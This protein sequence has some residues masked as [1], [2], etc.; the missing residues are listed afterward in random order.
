MAGLLGLL[1]L[2]AGAITAQDAGVAVSGRNTANVNT[3]GYSVESVNLSAQVGGPLLSGVIA[4]DTT[5]STDDFLSSQEWQ[6]AG[7]LGLSST[8][9]TITS[10]LTQVLT[11]QGQSL[12]QSY[13]SLFGSFNALA[14]SP[15]DTSLRQ[16]VVS[17]AQQMA[18]SYQQMA[19][20]I[21][22]S[23]AEADANIKAIAQSASA[24]A[25]QIA[26]LNATISTNSDPTLKDQRDLAAK[27]LVSM[28]GGHARI[29]PDGMMRVVVGSGQVLVDG[30]HAASLQ[31]AA[32]SAYGNHLRISVVDGN[33]TSDVTSAVGGKL[34]AHVQLRDVTSRN[35]A[36]AL[37]Q[38]AYDTATQI[39]AVHSAGAA[40]DGSTGHNLFAAPTQVSGA[41]A[42]M[43]VD[44]TVAANP[45][46]VAAGQVG[47]GSGDGSNAL[48][49][50]GMSDQLLAAGGSA[51]FTDQAIAIVDNVGV[52]AKNASDQQT[53]DSSRVDVLAAARTSVSG[54]S[55]QEELA[56]LAQFQHASEAA[57][58]FVSVVNDLLTNIITNL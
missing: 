51:T 4:G 21:A 5:R 31:T 58:K 49:I 20:A 45:A 50:S 19:A 17:N 2:G 10:S 36:A 16:Q 42:A 47:G 54:V 11:P 57:A 28:T 9:S 38:L 55:T 13:S 15:T 25:Q 43:A 44:S 34:G 32:D 6:A 40:L 12:I 3:E 18:L 8:A 26:K 14:A 53:L 48:A 41:A 7:D 1:D 22:Q 46:L 52:A 24:L 27:Q 35:A 37:D 56:K 30:I 39:N 33:H 29:D 23:Q